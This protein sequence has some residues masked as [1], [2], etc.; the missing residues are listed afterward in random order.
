LGFIKTLFKYKRDRLLEEEDYYISS[1]QIAKVLNH[2]EILNFF[3]NL[4]FLKKVDYFK[5]EK[6]Q[7]LM[8]NFRLNDIKF[9]FQ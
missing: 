2:N 3:S 9:I 6:V 7:K 8:V 1:C 4:F 5:F